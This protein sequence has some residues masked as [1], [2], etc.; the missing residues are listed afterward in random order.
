MYGYIAFYKGR[1]TEVHADTSLAARGKAA[2]IFKVPKKKE[3]EVTVMLA[4]KD[5]QPVTHTADF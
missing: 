2:A 4:E 5:G 1:R 3:H